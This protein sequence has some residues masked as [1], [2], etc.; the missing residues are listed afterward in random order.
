MERSS[1]GLS[2]F[3]NRKHQHI[4]AAIII[5]LFVISILARMAYLNRPLSNHHEW[6]T[7]TV[8]IHERIWYEQGGLKYKFCPPLTFENKADKNIAN[9][10]SNHKDA[11]GSYYYTSYPPFAYILPYLIFRLFNIYPSALSLQIFNLFFHFIS[12]IFIFLIIVLLTREHYQKRLNI[13]AIIGYAI[14]MFAP[15]TMWYQSNVYMA[16]MFVQPLFI[17]E[18]YLFLKLILSKDKKP[19]YL[20]FLGIVNL[21]AIYTEWLG[22]LLAFAICFYALLKIKKKEMRT[23]LYVVAA[24]AI[25]SLTL[26]VW[27]Y[28]QIDGLNAFIQASVGKYVA[29]SGIS[30]NTGLN[31]WNPASWK[32]I[33]SHYIHGYLPLLVLLFTFT[34]LYFYR[35]TGSLTSKAFSEKKVK[36][37]LYLSIVPVI[38]HHLVFFNFTAIHDFSALKS[39]VSIAII[40]AILYQSLTAYFQMDNLKGLKSLSPVAVNALIILMTIG[41][42]M[43]YLVINRH[44]SA[45]YMNIG[46]TIASASEKDEVIFINGYALPQMVL[47]AHRNIAPWV[48]EKY[49]KEL[50]KLNG[51]KRG[52]LFILSQGEE[53]VVEKKYINA[54]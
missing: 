6:L 44:W 15:A 21:L 4:T 49:A 48:N 35:A 14:Y 28:S 9:A 17:M 37:T 3:S 23:I 26:T 40:I 42:I 11:S 13:P 54:D 19:I 8:L 16:D 24:T 20:V 30:K 46:Q 18:I 2:G 38:L 41:S 1:L 52:V 39:S 25:A 50:I 22:L 53:R 47:Y 7:S 34:A 29:R 36:I 27:Q 51:A 5:L 10:A 43:Q 33:A 45:Q 31:Y 12:A 32:A